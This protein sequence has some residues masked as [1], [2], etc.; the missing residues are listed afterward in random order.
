[1]PNQDLLMVI[2]VLAGVAVTTCVLVVVGVRARRAH[3]ADG[4][5][6]RGADV[7]R[8]CGDLLGTSDF[9]WSVWQD[10]ASAKAMKLLLRD[11]DDRVISTMDV[12]SIPTDG[13][14]KRFHLGGRRYEIY[15]A[16]LMSNRTCLREA[17]EGTV[18]FSAD[19]GMRRTT[20]FAGEGEREM[21]VMPVTSVLRR[22]R[23]IEARG[24]EVGRIVKGLR[25]HP[26]ARVLSL[27]DEY[28][29]IVAK[30]FILASA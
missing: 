6:L 21:F 17:E 16:G 26:Y 8:A 13:V 5:A 1:M 9:L 23:P 30:V 25:G 24:R 7:A 2:A 10:T 19:H 29:S 22:V 15:K 12:P 18:L 20:F 4:R 27:P 11:A 14:L 3:D 28:A